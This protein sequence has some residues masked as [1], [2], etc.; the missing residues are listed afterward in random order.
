[1]MDDADRPQ[2]EEVAL[3]ALEGVRIGNAENAEAATGVTVMLFPGGAL[4]GADVSG[5]GPASRESALLSPLTADTPVNGIVL[6]GGSA[7]G[8]AASDGVMQ[9]L[10]E[11]GIGFDTGVARVP[12]VVQSCLYDL[13][14]GSATVRPDAAMGRA[15]CEA[16]WAGKAV[17]NGSFGAGAGATVGK[18]RGMRRGM[19]SGLGVCAVRL[20]GLVMAAVVAVNALGDICDERTGKTIAGL[21]NADRSGFADSRTAFYAL[22]DVGNLFAQSNTTIGAI[23]TNAAFSKAQLTKLA[24]MTRNAYARCIRPVGTL[25]DGDTIYAA[26][27]G[28]QRA[29]LNLAGALA[30][31]VM[32]RAIVRAVTAARTDDGEYLARC[33]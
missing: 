4:V 16:A 23:L 2:P 29:D 24:S 31:D 19:K 17:E 22:D 1:M 9:W 11:H 33:L 28:T 7:Y 10:E 8:L 20:N 21:L 12:I 26:S 3:S 30:A 5:G 18:L 6:S 25:V 14:Y 15:A 27:V 32:A 13:T